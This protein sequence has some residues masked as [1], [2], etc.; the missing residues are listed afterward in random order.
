MTG[1]K[2]KDPLAK[3]TLRPSMTETS[4]INGISTMSKTFAVPVQ[5]SSPIYKCAGA[6]PSFYGEV[7]SIQGQSNVLAINRIN[8][9]TAR[10]LCYNKH[11][12]AFYAEENAF[13]IFFM[14]G[15]MAMEGSFWKH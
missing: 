15:M 9:L 2:A 3:K 8:I 13:S 12:I 5:N 10:I 14:A 7:S 1:G 6:M 4:T 11:A